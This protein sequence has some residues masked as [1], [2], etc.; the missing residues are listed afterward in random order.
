MITLRKGSP[1]TWIAG[2]QRIPA[3]FLEYTSGACRIQFERDGQTKTVRVPLSFLTTQEK[4]CAPAPV[5]RL[6]DPPGVTIED[7][8]AW[9]KARF[10][11][12]RVLDSQEEVLFLALEKA[13]LS[14]VH[15][16]IAWNVF[17]AAGLDYAL[18][19]VKGWTDTAKGWTDT[20]KG[21]VRA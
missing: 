6:T 8:A 21:W 17:G 9:A 18:D 20:A 4:S 3:T 2:D 7:T 16:S 15:Q 10:A 14:P 1:V 19:T 13:N 11:L 12:K 5:T